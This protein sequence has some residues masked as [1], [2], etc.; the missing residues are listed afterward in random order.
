M[1]VDASF[2]LVQ[3]SATCDMETL[4]PRGIV[5]SLP[6]IFMVTNACDLIEGTSNSSKVAFLEEDPKVL[7]Q[8]K[9]PSSAYYT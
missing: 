5:A 8:V 3:T 9:E 7:L 6:T 4:M 1:E 2:S